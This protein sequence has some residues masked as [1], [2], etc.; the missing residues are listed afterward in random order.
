VGQLGAGVAHELNNPLTGILGHAQL[1]LEARP[2]ADPDHET[3][4]AIERLARRCRDVTQRL[5]RFSQQG[6]EPRPERVELNHVAEDA[7]ALGG[8]AAGDDGVPLDVALAS[9]SPPVRGDPGH[10]AQVVLALLA[11]ARTACAGK[12]GARV[13]LETRT[14]GDRAELVVRDGGRGIAPEH[15]PRLFEPFF[16]TKPGWRDVGLGLSVAYRIVA[17]HGGEIAVESAPGE[18]SAFTVRLPLA[19]PEV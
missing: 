3:L 19:G 4:L 1:L 10:L 5:L 6:A 14:A 18:G 11:N 2:P 17:D 8:G 12:P 9:P 16:T 7:V 13:R 15:L